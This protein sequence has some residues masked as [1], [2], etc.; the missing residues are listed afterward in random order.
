MPFQPL[1]A[2]YMRHGVA[3]SSLELEASIAYA[4]VLPWCLLA[5]FSKGFGQMSVV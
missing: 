4:G 1:V 3:S 2:L 5:A